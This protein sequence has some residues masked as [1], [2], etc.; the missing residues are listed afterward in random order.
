[1]EGWAGALKE[2]G[3]GCEGGREGGGGREVVGKYRNKEEG[4]IL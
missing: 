2:E 4:I 3:E 1:M